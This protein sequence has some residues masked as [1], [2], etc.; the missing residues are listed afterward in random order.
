MLIADENIN[1]SL[2]LKL[3]GF[4]YEVISIKQN[5]KGISDK[6]VIDLA[7]EK[8]GILIT[9]DKDFGK[10]VFAH[11]ITYNYFFEI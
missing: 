3:R 9:E 5:Y 2:I 11:N 1:S 4:G 8:N 10:W 6:E 7:K